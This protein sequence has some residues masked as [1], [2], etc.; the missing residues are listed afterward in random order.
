M[1]TKLAELAPVRLVIS[2]GP[3][4]KDFMVL[5]RLYANTGWRLTF[6]FLKSPGVLPG[7]GGMTIEC[8]GKDEIGDKCADADEYTFIGRWFDSIT[9]VD[10]K[11][12][13]PN[14]LYVGTYNTRTRKGLCQRFTPEQFIDAPL[15]RILFKRVFGINDIHDSG[16]V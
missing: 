9:M 13:K 16:E 12:A 10:G 8:I 4:F 2:D 14:Y 6:N 5:S 7:E 15:A 11:W 1:F 3:P